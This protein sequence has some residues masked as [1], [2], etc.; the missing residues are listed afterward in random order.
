LDT[1]K[2]PKVAIILLNWN[3]WRDTL[4]CL[5]S[6]LDISYV[7]YQ[8]FLVDN[9][10]TDGSVERIKKWC[11]ERGFD[12][13]KKSSD[14]KI[15][16][17]QNDK[18]YG[19]SGGN[20]RGIR[21]AMGLSY[22]KYFWLLNNDTVVDENSLTEMVKVAEPRDKA[23]IIGSKVFDYGDRSHIQTIGENKVVWPHMKRRKEIPDKETILDVKWVRGASL[24]I[25]N[26]LVLEIGLLDEKLFIYFEDKDWCASALKKGW[27]IYTALN[28]RIFHKEGAS[29]NTQILHKRLFGMNVQRLTL[30]NF[31]IKLYYESRNGIYFVKKQFPLSFIPYLF[32]R[33]LHLIFQAILYD[34]H[35]MKRTGVILR[36]TMDGVIGKMGKD[37]MYY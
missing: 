20:N 13:D 1:K 21:F 27:K 32:F 23:G 15:I 18:N 26:E 5:E 6:L 28:S 29:T 34:D 14:E 36:G 31:R 8:I 3:G 25:K 17:I 4:E 37:N 16:L 10:S 35:K 9:H 30:E 12:L 22:F 33:T 7:N 19:F 11:R 24:L 2:Y